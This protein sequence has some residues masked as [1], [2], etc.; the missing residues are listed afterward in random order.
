[1]TDLLSVNPSSFLDDWLR[2]LPR[3]SK[4][5]CL[6]GGYVMPVSGNSQS[7]TGIG[8][9]GAAVGPG[10]AFIL[11]GRQRERMSV[12]FRTGSHAVVAWK[13]VRSAMLV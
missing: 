9:F 13:P 5:I 1:M 7:V 11:R 12:A 2:H 6:G 3:M 4:V 10:G 8:V